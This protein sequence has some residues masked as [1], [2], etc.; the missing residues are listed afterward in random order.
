MPCARSPAA[1]GSSRFLLRRRIRR[2]RRA[3]HRRGGRLP[4]GGRGG[5]AR[6]AEEGAGGDQGATGGGWRSRPGGAGWDAGVWGRLSELP[7]RDQRAARPCACASL[8]EHPN[9]AKRDHPKSGQRAGLPPFARF[10]P[11][12]AL[13]ECTS[14]LPSGSL[15]SA[16]TRLQ[17]ALRPLDTGEG[18]KQVP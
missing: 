17:H 1:W 15:R 14:R 4:A 2:S 11:D 7:R 13:L 9:P 5:S 8:G 10:S 12:T 18:R 3:G 16:L 6:R